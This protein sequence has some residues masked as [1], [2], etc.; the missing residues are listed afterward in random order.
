MEK[1]FV[2]KKFTQF[3]TSRTLKIDLFEIPD[4]RNIE[5]L[6][7]NYELLFLDQANFSSDVSQIL[8]LQFSYLELL[9]LPC[10]PYQTLPLPTEPLFNSILSTFFICFFILSY[11]IRPHVL[12]QTIC[13]S[14]P[15]KFNI[16]LYTYQFAL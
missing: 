5:K 6:F 4:N 15:I 7:S 2:A 9:C 1:V 12:C 11:S 8:M 16:K 13:Q 3:K 10:H 14:K